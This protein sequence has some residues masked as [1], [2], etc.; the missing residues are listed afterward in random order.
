VCYVITIVRKKHFEFLLFSYS[1]YHLH[2]LEMTKGSKTMKKGTPKTTNCLHTQ[3]RTKGNNIVVE[4]E[5][6]NEKH[7]GGWGRWG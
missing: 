3:E 7:G 5:S 4:K 1:S 2:T 6:K